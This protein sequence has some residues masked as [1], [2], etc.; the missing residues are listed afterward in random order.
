MSTAGINAAVDTAIED[1][2]EEMDAAWPWTPEQIE[3]GLTVDTEQM[4]VMVGAIVRAVLERLEAQGTA[5]GSPIQ[6]DE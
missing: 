3:Q 2:L 6:I 4:R 1:A 5:G